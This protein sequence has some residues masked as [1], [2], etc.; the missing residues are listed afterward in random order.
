MIMSSD[1]PQ[2]RIQAVCIGQKAARVLSRPLRGT[3]LLISHKGW[4]IG[5]DSA[6][7]LICDSAYG[8]VPIGVGVNGFEGCMSYDKALEG[9][10]VEFSSG[11]LHLPVCSLDISK[12]ASAPV[13]PK[14]CS[15]E[16]AR[17]ALPCIRE[18]LYAHRKG[19]MYRLIPECCLLIHG[20]IP[21]VAG[22]ED[23]YLR[24]TR[25][26]LSELF[27]SLGSNNKV[28]IQDAVRSLIGLGPGLTPSADDWLTAFIY[29]A[30]RLSFSPEINTTAE[31][32]E[33]YS[34]ERTNLISAAYLKSS[35]AGD[36]YQLLDDILLCNS[37]ACA[38]RLLGIGSSSGA[39]MLSGIYFAIE[40]SILHITPL[41]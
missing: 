37:P 32:I 25:L 39:D 19:Y 4:Y 23:A 14:A 12:A 7:V 22:S 11:C 1:L 30:L 9:A 20:C 24:E 2:M 27:R 6:V 33:A 40:Y 26:R 21:T 10:P 34:A 18:A 29:A 5:F 8:I 35:A 36:Y 28:G 38:K 17:E 16:K 3:I 15:P 13:R 31:A 41:I